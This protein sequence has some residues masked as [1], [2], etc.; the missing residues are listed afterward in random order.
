ML[1]IGG[2]P[3][4][5]LAG[6]QAG[7]L[8]GRTRRTKQG[9]SPRGPPSEMCGV[10][11]SEVG[12]VAL[13]LAPCSVRKSRCDSPARPGAG[14]HPRAWLRTRWH[15]GGRWCRRVP[16][17]RGVPAVRGRPLWSELPAQGSFR[18]FFPLAIDRPSVRVQFVDSS[19]F[20]HFH[21]SPPWV[22]AFLLKTSW[23]KQCP[24]RTMSQEGGLGLR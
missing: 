19:L 3:P 11:S 5:V 6:H 23:W 21:V 8:A 7:H 13:G 22:A 17:A 16:D 24:K 18:H 15:I 20:A 2:F 1:T 14:R 10:T 4:M 9:L 12:S